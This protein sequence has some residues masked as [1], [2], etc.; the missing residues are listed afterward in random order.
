[1]TDQEKAV[2]SDL[3]ALRTAVANYMQSEGCS[4]CQG[5]DHEYHKSIL[6]MM[7]DVPSYSD[8]SGW[9]FDKFRSK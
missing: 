7:L 1:M 6:A 9:D 5:S 3:E 4:C 8:G 2:I